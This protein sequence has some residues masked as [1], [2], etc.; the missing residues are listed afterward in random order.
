MAMLRSNSPRSDETTSTVPAPVNPPDPVDELS[1]RGDVE[2][3][4]GWAINSA[5]RVVERKVEL[6]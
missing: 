2:S 3:M 1:E 4:S 5:E 6:S